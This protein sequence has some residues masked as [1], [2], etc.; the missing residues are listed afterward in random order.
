MLRTVHFLDENTIEGKWVKYGYLKVK[1]R[2]PEKLAF[3]LIIHNNF[4]EL[5]FSCSHTRL[6]TFRNSLH[7]F[8]SALLFQP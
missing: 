4:L 6:Q 7:F 1:R 2:E 5:V 3:H 8:P